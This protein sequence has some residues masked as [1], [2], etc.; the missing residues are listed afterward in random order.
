MQHLYKY[1]DKPE[2][3]LKDGY[4]RASQLSALNDPLEA[5]YN[6]ATLN[7]IC[8]DYELDAKVVLR[9]VDELGVI[10]LTESKD[11]LLMWSH[12]ANYHEGA[13]IEFKIETKYRTSC[14]GDL[15]LDETYKLL[16]KLDKK[17][18]KAIIPA[19]KK[20]KIGL[21]SDLVVSGL[22]EGNESHKRL[23]TGECLPVRYRPSPIC[24]TT[25][26]D[27]NLGDL[28]WTGKEDRLSFELFRQK[29][30]AWSYEKEH[31]I[32]LK[33]AQAHR[34]QIDS[35]AELDRLVHEFKMNEMFL[36][37]LNAIAKKK[38]DDPK[39][40][41]DLDEV[42]NKDDRMAYGRTLAKLSNNA[43]NLYLF[44]T[45]ERHLWS[46]SF[47]CKASPEDINKWSILAKAR[48]KSI[49]EY[50]AEFLSNH[51]ALKFEKK[52]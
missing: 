15:D 1:T 52:A 31:R 16:E 25:M 38:N 24:H 6:K 19:Y 45:D 21:L 26:S 5:S 48:N 18:R 29:S 41:F 43:K 2:L 40:I 12:Y 42:P 14:I 36:E 30:D 20:K 49:E 27:S 51:Y 50:K 37:E 47:G 3:F 39:I 28:D 33:L 35:Q 22:S 7:K 32:T 10:C 4:L 46:I 44:R 13:V 23:F 8:E 9:G 11:N 17:E 34:V